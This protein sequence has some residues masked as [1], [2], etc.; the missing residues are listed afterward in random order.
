MAQTSVRYRRTNPSPHHAC[1]TRLSWK[2]SNSRSRLYTAQLHP[3]GP[4]RTRSRIPPFLH[5]EPLQL[6]SISSQLLEAIGVC[7]RFTHLV[8][9]VAY[10]I[11]GRL[12]LRFCATQALTP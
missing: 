2:R 9:G 3:Q 8:G 5:R 12:Q 6:T 4:E 1:C 7:W 10:A 11:N